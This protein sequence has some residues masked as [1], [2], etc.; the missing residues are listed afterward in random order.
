MPDEPEF[1]LHNL[2]DGKNQLPQIV[3]RLPHV[4]RGTHVCAHAVARQEDR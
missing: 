2:H 4:H 3:L 1:D